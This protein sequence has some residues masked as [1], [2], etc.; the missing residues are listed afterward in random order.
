LSG[1][2]LAWPIS[3]RILPDTVEQLAV[4]DLTFFLRFLWSYLGWRLML[5][6]T[7]IGVAAVLEGL[8]VGLI[9]PILEGADSGGIFTEFITSLFKIVNLDY[10]L[11]LAL[12]FMGVFFVLRTAFLI[13]QELF[14]QRII[15]TL[16]VKL[17]TDLIEDLYT[18]NHLY[19]A[20]REQ[21]FLTNAIALEYSRVANAF[22]L[23]MRLVVG[24][25]FA[26]VYGILPLLI[27][28]SAT[29]VFVLLAGPGYFV[30]RRL[31]VI[32]RGLSIR[33]AANNAEIQ[34]QVG[35]LLRH[36]KYLQATRS[37]FNVLQRAFKEITEQGNL[38]YKEA[39]LNS[40]ITRGSELVMFGIVILIL[41]YYVVIQGATLIAMLF[42]I[43]LIRRAVLFMLTVQETFR[44]FV[45]SAGSIR[46]FRTLTQEVADQQEIVNREGAAPDF[47]S[48]LVLNHVSFGYGSGP[49]VLK[50]VS[51][52]IPPKQTTA[53]VGASGSGK[54]TLATLITGIIKPTSGAL[55][56]GGHTYTEMDQ[57]TLRKGIGY[58]TQ[59][60]VI[61]TDTIKNN[62][63]MFG[64]ASTTDIDSALN[65]AHLRG[66]I[67]SLPDNVD[68]VLT[69]AG[70][71]V[72]GGQ[73]QRINIARELFKDVKLLIFDEA[74]SS[75]DSESEREVQSNIDDFRGDKTVVII[76]HRLSTV[77]NSD[78]ILL[79][80]DGT[81]LE[82]GTYQEL[83]ARGGAFRQMVDQQA[84]GTGSSAPDEGE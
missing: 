73:R 84:L 53:I 65:R 21:G 59:E 54:S 46:V 66:F 10:S 9:F 70:L 52:S 2:C 33:R 57:W 74:T 72:S 17:K 13:Y 1:S 71:N 26:I 56:L 78:Q 49:E 36:F 67:D 18:A 22:E 82:Q 60:S 45:G 34:S 79:L 44:S 35:Q 32:T 29:V 68:T 48:P 27:D 83:Y 40:M 15:A 64:E 28:I 62:I 24:V 63:A 6:I 25:G 11:G 50:D 43:F 12:V 55:S 20:K 38:T 76:A 23:V 41:Y 31:I 19:Y 51:F 37:G 14:A 30:L 5:W 69:D 80:S 77:Q 7:L 3:T 81:V 39:R 61:F 47:A 75:L 58:V 4:N 42:L 16:M 8:S